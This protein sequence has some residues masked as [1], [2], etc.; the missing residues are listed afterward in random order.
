MRFMLAAALGLVAASMTIPLAAN[1]D[2]SSD[3]RGMCERVSR[4]DGV[5]PAAITPFCAC[6]TDRAMANDAALYRELW[7]AATTQPNLDARMAML[8]EPARAAVQA[9]RAP[10]G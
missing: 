4:D 9:C 1:A 2:Q 6:L 3:F 10:P 8:S 7:T 5:P